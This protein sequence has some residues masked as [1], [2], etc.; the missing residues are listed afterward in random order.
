M[1]KISLSALAVGVVRRRHYL[2]KLW[3]IVASNLA[4]EYSLRHRKKLVAIHVRESLQA[5]VIIFIL[6]IE[7]EGS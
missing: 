1:W 7:R 6:R 3:Q 2:R 4:C 5:A